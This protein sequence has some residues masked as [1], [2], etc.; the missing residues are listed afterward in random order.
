MPRPTRRR[1]FL[2]PAAGLIVLRRIK[3][4][5]NSLAHYRYEVADLVDHAADG[6]RVFE[7]DDLADALQTQAAHRG[8]VVLARAS[9]TL[10][11]RHLQLLVLSHHV[12]R[13]S[14]TVLPRLAAMS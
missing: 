4:S 9:D 12:P 8:A 6:L 2:L 14:S 11:E 5:R 3:D 13:I 10:D 7:L 1:F